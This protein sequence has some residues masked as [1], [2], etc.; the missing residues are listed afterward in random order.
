MLPRDVTHFIVRSALETAHTGQCIVPR[1]A[2]YAAIMHGKS[3]VQIPVLYI[4]LR[5]GGHACCY[6]KPTVSES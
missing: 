1:I 5:E 3:I 6:P 4:Y 2:E